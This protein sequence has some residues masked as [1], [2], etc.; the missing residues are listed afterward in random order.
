M[1]VLGVSL[2]TNAVITSYDVEQTANHEEVLETG[3]KRAE[4]MVKLVKEFLISLP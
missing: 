4:D 1:R 2:V 3:R